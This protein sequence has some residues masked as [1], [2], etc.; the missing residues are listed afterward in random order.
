MET[1]LGG[2]IAAVSRLG[3]SL[4]TNRNDP[5]EQPGPHQ[6]TMKYQK[7]TRLP[8]AVADGSAS[9]ARTSLSAP[10]RTLLQACEAILDVLGNFFVLCDLLVGLV[11]LVQGLEQRRRCP[12]SD[13]QF[14]GRAIPNGPSP[15]AKRKPCVSISVTVM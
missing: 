15:M 4:A 14:P 13:E 6:A 1:R 2:R 10:G 12:S 5:V 8:S 3:T 11:S 7:L 9:S